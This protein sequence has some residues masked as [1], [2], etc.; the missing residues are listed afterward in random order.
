MKI[1][2]ING[3]P[4][5]KNSASENILNTLKKLFTESNVISEYNFR[6]PKLDTK[7]IEEISKCNVIVFAFPLYIDEIPAHL[8]SCLYQMETYFKTNLNHDIK[9]YVLVNCGF[10]EGKQGLIALEMMENWCKKAEISWGQGIGIGGGG[11]L[12]GMASVPDGQGP[13]KNVWNALNILS[14]N[15]SNCISS[16]NIFV[17]PNLPRFLYKIG[18]DAGW[19]QQIKS[20]G[21]RSKDLFI[22]K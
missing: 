17:S 7:E 18:G 5:V 9:V 2:L 16:E 13:K 14:K 6:T 8:K 12:S 11:M 20:N 19:R 4:K 22:K 10:Y 15:V 21:L 1:A 3:S